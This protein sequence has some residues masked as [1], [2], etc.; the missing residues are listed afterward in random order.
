[1]TCGTLFSKPC[2]QLTHNFTQILKWEMH[3]CLNAYTN[4]SYGLFCLCDLGVH[5][6]PTDSAKEIK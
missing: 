2:K 6:M 1:M 5:A 3:T 4:F